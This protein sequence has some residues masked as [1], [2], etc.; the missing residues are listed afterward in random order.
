VSRPSYNELRER[1]LCERMERHRSQIE[2][3]A[4]RYGIPFDDETDIFDL[5]RAVN[6]VEEEK[7]WPALEERARALG[8]PTHMGVRFFGRWVFKKRREY[9]AVSLDCYREE[10]YRR[11]LGK[12]GE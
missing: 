6:A 11:L 5:S 8:V 4:R 7:R 9:A 3:D 2:E 1:E 12:Y 10:E